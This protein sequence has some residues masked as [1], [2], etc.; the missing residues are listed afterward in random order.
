MDNKERELIVKRINNLL[1]LTGSVINKY[2]RNYALYNQTSVADF[3]GRNP[4]A[5][6]VIQNGMKINADYP[7]I[8]IIKSCIDAVVSSIATAKPRPFVN[9]VKGSYKTITIARQLQ[10]FLDF[11]F[12]EEDLYNKNC[13]ALRDACLFDSGYVYIDEVDLKSFNI[14]PWCVYTDPNEKE[15]K[16]VYILFNNTSVDSLPEWIE[17]ELTN[18]E[19]DLLYINYG[20]YYNTKLHKKAL[21]INGEVRKITDFQSNKI[22]VVRICY[23]EPIASDHCLSIADILVGLQ[24]E[25]NILSRTIALASKKNPAQT[26]LLKNASNIAVGELNNEIGNIIQYN[27]ESDDS[28]VS[29]VTPSFISEQYEKL[30]ETDIRRA[31]DL[32][33]KSQTSASGRRETGVESGIALA[34]VADMQNER[35]QILLNNFINLFISEAKL[36]QEIGMSDSTIITPSRYELKLTWKDVRED[37]LKMRIEFSSADSLSKDPTEK[38]KQLKFLAEQGIIPATQIPALLEIP[39]INRGFSAANNGYNCAMSIID[40]CIYD[41]KYELPFYV[42]FEL[43]KEMIVNTMLSLRAAEGATDSNEK[44]IAKLK[45]LFEVALENQQQLDS[46]QEKTSEISVNANNAYSQPAMEAEVANPYDTG[47]SGNSNVSAGTD[48]ISYNN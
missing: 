7:S 21:T 10:I 41:D 13:E 3:K 33:G 42:P 40:A 1:S 15:K 17:K 30:R 29:I 37:Y 2:Y 23:T 47:A 4:L 35:F 6:G 5:P 16:Q 24:K 9:T 28:P 11:Y 43:L 19:K 32:V 14:R 12:S 31:Y 36:I 26:I 22:P 48:D 8:N 18:S 44:D 34:T 27:A 20:L 39:D 38:F 45:K 46:L 25:I